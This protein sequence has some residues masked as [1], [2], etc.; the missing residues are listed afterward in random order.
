MDGLAIDAAATS[1]DT[2]WRTRQPVS[3]IVEQYPAVQT[4]EH[5]YA[6]GTQWARLRVRQGA[7]RRGYKV[8]LTSHEA[9]RRH[10]LDAPIRGVLFDDMVRSVEDGLDAGRYIAPR[11]E[12]ELAFVMDGVP[13]TREW[14]ARDLD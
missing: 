4:L 6:I 12:V 1:L 2:A 5:A 10:G 11:I 8:G 14:T 3:S 9:M 13:C 7:Q